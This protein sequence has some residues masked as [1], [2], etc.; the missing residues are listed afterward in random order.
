MLPLGKVAHL[1]MIDADCAAQYTLPQTD[2]YKKINFL[3]DPGVPGPIYGSSC[4]SLTDTCFADLTDVTL[5][6]EDTNPI[7]LTILNL[8][9]FFP[10]QNISSVDFQVL[11]LLS[12]FD[13]MGLSFLSDPGV[14][15]P[16]YGS[17]SLS[18]SN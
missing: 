9:S 7:P 16:I 3:S 5:A 15:G 8:T 12:I 17:A 18:L 2:L 14:P 6:V 13:F 11:S 4:L 10:C 1:F